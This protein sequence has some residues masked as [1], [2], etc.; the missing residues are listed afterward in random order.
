MSGNDELAF[1]RIASEETAERMSKAQAPVHLI[2]A[3]ILGCAK[4]HMES[5]DVIGSEAII[6][7]LQFGIQEARH[8]VSRNPT[9]ASQ[10]AADCDY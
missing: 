9:T 7:A 2:Y 3:A 6:N 1:E 5:G 10:I 4:E 8:W